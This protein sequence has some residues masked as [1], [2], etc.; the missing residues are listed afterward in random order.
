MTIHSDPRSEP[1][2]PDGRPQYP[3][4][5]PFKFNPDGVVQRYAGNTTVCHIPPS[6]PLLP[7]LQ[8]A[9]DTISAHPKFAKVI[10]LLPPS[11]WHMTVFDGV[12][13]QECE[14]GMWPPGLAKKPLAEA[15]AAFAERL[16]VFG[17]QLEAEG[18]A[19]PYR[20][21][22]TG[23]EFPAPVGIG[24]QVVGATPE[25]EKRMRRLRDRLSDV[26]GFKAP[27]HEVYGFHVTIAYFLR[28]FDGDDGVELGE[29]LCEL[30][31]PLDVEFELGAVEF[32][33]FDTMLAFPRL[34]YLGQE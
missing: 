34:F 13:E 19:P 30:E 21:K 7:G 9:Y 20:M 8:N 25:E 32:C 16:R 2:I 3:I 33:T 24:L 11:S 15:T 1:S 12:R 22:S 10:R 18:L 14:P 28:H 23:I 17:P 27:N 5:V 26:L 29:L 4:G 6:S 31:K